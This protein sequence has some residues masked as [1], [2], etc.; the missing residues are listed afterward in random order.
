MNVPKHPADVVRVGGS[1]KVEVAVP[2]GHGG[3]TRYP[4]RWLLGHFDD[5]L[6]DKPPCPF[7]LEQDRV[8][9]SKGAAWMT[10]LFV[11][12]EVLRYGMP[13]AD[14][15]LQQVLLVEEANDARPRQHPVV[16][17]LT[18]EINQFCQSICVAVFAQCLIK[19][20]T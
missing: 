6:L 15:L 17:H 8:Q 11:V 13:A 5:L 14:L 12:G 20:A 2:F 19:I 7:A 16:P 18:K 3:P 10:E 9:G 1:C 4:A